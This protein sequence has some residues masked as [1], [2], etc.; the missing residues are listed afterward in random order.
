MCDTFRGVAVPELVALAEDLYHGKVSK[1]EAAAIFN[2]KVTGPVQLGSTHLSYLA[3]ALGV[4]EK[5]IEPDYVSMF[6]NHDML[7]IL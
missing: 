3:H 2:T 7:D 1:E 6:L 5:H 4:A